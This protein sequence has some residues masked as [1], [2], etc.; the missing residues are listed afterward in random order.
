MVHE[1]R[2]DPLKVILGSIIGAHVEEQEGVAIRGLDEPRQ[3]L[4]HI[5]NLSSWQAADFL[6]FPVWMA[7]RWLSPSEQRVP[8]H[9]RP[10]SPLGSGGRGTPNPST[11]HLMPSNWRSLL[12]LPSLRCILWSTLR[13]STC[14]ENMKM[15]T[16]LYRHCWY[17]DAPHSS[18][19]GHMMPNFFTVL[20]SPMCSLL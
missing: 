6:V 3:S 7:D 10:P 14:G 17:L 15:V 4:C 19:G 9:H 18:S 20:L 8:D 12:L 1:V 5:A 11:V 13:I 2:R 16:Y